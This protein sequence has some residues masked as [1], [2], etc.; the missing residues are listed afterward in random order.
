MSDKYSITADEAIEEQA[1]QEQERQEKARQEHLTRDVTQEIEETI[2]T[3]ISAKYKEFILLQF[4]LHCDEYDASNIIVA[5]ARYGRN[6]D[7]SFLQHCVERKKYCWNEMILIGTAYPEMH[8][9]RYAIR[10]M[11]I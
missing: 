4:Q 5:T 2:G 3:T 11:R 9:A 7:A 8:D 6:T 1:R 10:K